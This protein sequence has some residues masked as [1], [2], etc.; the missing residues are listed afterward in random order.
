MARTRKTADT[1]TAEQDMTTEIL[2]AEDEGAGGED[3]EVGEVSS[4]TTTDEPVFDSI[5]MS[6][7]LQVTNHGEKCWVGAIKQWIEE[8]QSFLTFENES[9]KQ[10]LIAVLTQLNMFAN[11]DRFEWVGQYAKSIFNQHWI[12]R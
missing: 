5:D 4:E 1:E 2:L 3:L 10:K 8:G 12:D 7:T 9:E 6:L 11:Y